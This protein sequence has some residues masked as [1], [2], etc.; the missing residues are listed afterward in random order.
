MVR[1]R[2]KLVFLLCL[3]VLF[4]LVVSAQDDLPIDENYTISLPKS[5]DWES[6][7]PSLGY[8]VTGDIYALLIVDPV[9]LSEFVLV[10]PN[11]SIETILIEAY[12]V[13][14]DGT[15]PR[16]ADI[17]PLN[18]DGRTGAAWSYVLEEDDLVGLFILLEMSDGTYGVMDIYA[19][20]DSYDDPETE[21]EDVI[22]SFDAVNAVSGN[23]QPATG[24]ACLV[25]T[26]QAR[27][28]ALRVGPGENRTSVAFLP[29]GVEVEV[30]GVFV[31]DDGTEWFQLNKDQAA[32]QSAAA[33]LW[34]ERGDADETGDCDA[35]GN[36]SAP[37]IVPIAVVPP[38]A[39]PG[40][41]G[42][43]QPPAAG[44]I[45]PTGGEWTLTLNPTTNASCLG[46]PNVPI[47]SNELFSQMVYYSF[48]VN[49]TGGIT[50][51]GDFLARTPGSNFFQGSFTFDDGSNSQLRLTF[52][53]A[54]FASGSL[55]TN[56]TIDG[57]ACSGTTTFN[58]N[59]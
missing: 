46:G 55:T 31:E 23:Q 51:E 16:A 56:F 13:L 12:S 9:E 34:M 41:G 58:F 14:Y 27:T 2:L 28:I 48:V 19:Y 32:P 40:G 29:V 42:A 3:F 6:A 52:S 37:P 35:V 39:A 47:P 10:S 50:M 1:Q 4:P 25:A 7:D 21:L 45:T 44:T 57:T 8:F 53:S 54:T 24:E 59:R 20:T 33:E 22:S 17:E 43:A 36:A 49:V 15:M 30:T 26:D 38:T 5:W 11:D 18:V